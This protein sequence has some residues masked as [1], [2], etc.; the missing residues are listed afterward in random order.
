MRFTL[1]PTNPCAILLCHLAPLSPTGA[2]HGS[3]WLSTQQFFALI[4]CLRALWLLLA[5][6]Q[7]KNA[8]CTIDPSRNPNTSSN[9]QVSSTHSTSHHESTVAKSGIPSSSTH[10]SSTSSAT[11]HHQHH[12]MSHH[13][14]SGAASTNPSAAMVPPISIPRPSSP[15]MDVDILGLSPSRQ[16]PEDI[17]QLPPSP[18]SSSSHPTKAGKSKDDSTPS[19]VSASKDTTR[20]SAATASTTQVKPEKSVKSEKVR[21]VSSASAA[22]APTSTAP[23]A[24]STAASSTAS[25]PSR[26][27]LKGHA[28]EVVS[29][30][31]NPRNP[32]LLATC[33]SDSTVRLW[34]LQQGLARASSAA[35]HHGAKVKP[36]MT[37]PSQVVS[38]QWS[39]SGSSLAT[40]C[41]DGSVRLWDAGVGV[42]KTQLN[43]KLSAHSGAVFALRWNQTGSLLAS[44]GADR[45]LCLWNPATPVTSGNSSSTATLTYKFEKLHEDGILDVDFGSDNW[46]ATASVDK[47]LRLLRYSP[48]F[49]SPAAVTESPSLGATDSSS[50]TYVGPKISAKGHTQSVNSVRW[51][52]L[53]PG[54]LASGSDDSSIRLWSVPIDA[55]GSGSAAL[56]SQLESSKIL[57]GHTKEVYTLRWHPSVSQ[58]ASA[59]FDTTV[60]LW[61][62]EQTA[63]TNTLT[64]HSEAVLSLDYS[65]S[66]QLLASGSQDKTVCVW[67]SRTASA[68]KQFTCSGCVLDVAVNP[69][70]DRV[71]ACCSDNSAVVFDLR[72]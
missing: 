28:A 51:S 2:C 66:G 3:P 5:H 17:P 62:P 32:E 42:P 7:T 34:T 25:K 15:A 44:A 19:L 11:Q 67:D 10:S 49:L 56:E 45:S 39:P 69:A 60:K 63:A 12:S 27:L 22:P 8:P 21:A 24:A 9:P 23:A 29:C 47:T 46:I 55:S 43:T 18:T 57:S 30:G 64:S 1:S 54:L 31:W 13:A 72:M 40:A 65:P 36:G 58:I 20:S 53:N 33:S 38:V 41:F 71:A 70:E 61:D 14:S 52:P 50:S 4:Q 37:P 48:S 16:S 59:S 68:V 6:H 35:L 26:L